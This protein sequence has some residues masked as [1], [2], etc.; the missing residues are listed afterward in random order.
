MHNKVKSLEGEKSKL[1][2]KLIRLCFNMK[3]HKLIMLQAQGNFDVVET[4]Y[5]HL[6]QKFTKL[7]KLGSTQIF[8]C[9]CT[10]C[11]ICK[12]TIGKHNSIFFCQHFIGF[13][14]SLNAIFFWNKIMFNF[15]LGDI[16]LVA[17]MKILE[18]EILQKHISSV[19]ATSQRSL[20]RTWMFLHVN[21]IVQK[22]LGNIDITS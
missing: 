17:S 8:N 13:I 3:D 14:G 18:L 4:S 16:K 9:C 5:Q 21:Y 10:W 12:G 15:C 20:A 1:L 7:K 19:L 22:T 11:S 6:H 2:E